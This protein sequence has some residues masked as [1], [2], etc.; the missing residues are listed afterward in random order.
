MEEWINSD[1]YEICINH[2]TEPPFSGKYNNS[3]LEG[4]TSVHVGKLFS[5][6]AKFDSVQDSQVFGNLI[7][8]EKFEFISDTSYGMVRT[9]RK[10]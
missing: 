10:L 2:G 4:S 1:Q 9:E 3:K 5:S 7:D 8:D 6:E